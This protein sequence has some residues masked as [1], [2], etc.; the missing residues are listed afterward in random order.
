MSSHNC[1]SRTHEA[2]CL[3]VLGLQTAEGTLLVCD[4]N[5]EGCEVRA[6]E[7]LATRSASGGFTRWGC[8]SVFV[9]L[10]PET[11]THKRGFLK[12]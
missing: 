6:Y 4:I 10:S 7:A 11:R 5:D 3:S 9:R 12:N 2:S 8:P 1:V